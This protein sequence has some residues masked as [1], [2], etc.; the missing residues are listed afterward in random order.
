MNFL[1][2][3]SKRRASGVEKLY[4]EITRF[5]IRLI[6]D[7]SHL[8]FDFGIAFSQIRSIIGKQKNSDF[9]APADK[10]ALYSVAFNHQWSVQKQPRREPRWIAKG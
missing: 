1:F 6:V 5:K 10:P 2:Q 8:L 9:I 4:A 3:I 7:G